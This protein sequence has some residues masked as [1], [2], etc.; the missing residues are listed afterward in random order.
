MV[1]WILIAHGSQIDRRLIADGSHID[2]R[3]ITD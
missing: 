3:L 2:R 1:R